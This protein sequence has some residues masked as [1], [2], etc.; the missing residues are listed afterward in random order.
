MSVH[1]LCWKFKCRL[2]WKLLW[3]LLKLRWWF[4]C[5]ILTEF[6]TRVLLDVLSASCGSKPEF[7]LRLSWNDGT[8]ERPASASVQGTDTLTVGLLGRPLASSDSSD[9]WI[10]K[11]LKMNSVPSCPHLQLALLIMTVRSSN[12]HQAGC[13]FKV[14]WQNILDSRLFKEPFPKTFLL[15][16][17]GSVAH[18]QA[19]CLH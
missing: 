19:H 1:C 3:S 10:Q 15:W 8:M 18:K 4:Q 6:K 16:L 2:E 17:F 14:G 5:V 12:L 11:T 13:C 9:D 7:L